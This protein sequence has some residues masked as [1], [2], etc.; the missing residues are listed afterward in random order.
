MG[1]DVEVREHETV[2]V[3]AI[4][5]TNGVLV[6]G[7]GVDIDLSDP[8][9]CAVAL[10]QVRAFETQFG[11]VKRTLTDAIVSHYRL[12]GERSL[13]LPNRSRAEVKAGTRNIIDPDILEE[14]L[15]E[16]GMPEDR[17]DAL[18]TTTHERRVDARKAKTAATANPD[19]KVAL[20]AATSTYQET[21]SVTIRRR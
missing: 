20:E 16:A 9:A 2:G 21:P 12:T 3:P 7:S 14:R 11:E 6:E 13:E 19:Y 10:D 15:R 1:N 17:I 8:V 4:V 5:D 18:I